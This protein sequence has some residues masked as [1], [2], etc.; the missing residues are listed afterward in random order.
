MNLQLF[1][2]EDFML[3]DSFVRYCL[4]SNDEDV[5]FWND[6]IARNPHKKAET[7][8]AKE[9]VLRLGMGLTPDE[10]Q[11]EFRKLR[12]LIETGDSRRHRFSKYLPYVAAAVLLTC[13]AVTWIWKTPAHNTVA[14]SAMTYTTWKA[15]SV[16]KQVLLA[17]GS[18]V[19]LNRNS[20]LRVPDNYNQEERHLILE[21]E[22]WYEVAKKENCPFTVTAGKTTVQ[23]LG[24]VFKVRAY[25]FD[26]SVMVSLISGKV[27]VQAAKE[28]KELSPD[29]YVK[30]VNGQLL[31][32]T[33]DAAREQDWR[34]GKLYFKDAS[35]EELAKLL[36]FWYGIKV[37][38]TPGNYQ[39]IHFNGEFVN[40]PLPAVLASISYITNLKIAVSKGELYINH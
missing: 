37:H 29:Q 39:P 2:A 1:T 33:F 12:A 8:Q 13:V 14:T 15:D 28:T 20:V 31:S 38:I 17:D 21:G 25:G 19:I 10:K 23:A 40:K 16:R 27:R 35:L 34:N 7:D 18:T 22:A 9:W 5:A 32:G 36:E 6:W 11:E 30:A 26:S 24:T 3:N 4:Q